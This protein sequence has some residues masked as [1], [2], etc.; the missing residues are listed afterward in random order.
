MFSSFKCSGRASWWKLCSKKGETGGAKMCCLRESFTWGWVDKKGDT[1]GLVDI[2]HHCVLTSQMPLSSSNNRAE[3]WTEWISTTHFKHG[4]HIRLRVLPL[5]TCTHCTR[6]NKRVSWVVGGI[7]K[8][9]YKY[10]FFL[11]VRVYVCM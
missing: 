7:G 4:N 10:I 9:I 11:S 5:F 2:L 3:N 1:L 6:Q 8:I